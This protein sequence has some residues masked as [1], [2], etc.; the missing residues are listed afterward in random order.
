M[1]KQKIKRLLID[2]AKL[3]KELRIANE[4]SNFS[5]MIYLREKMDNIREEIEMLEEFE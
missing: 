3:G 4:K 5:R 1:N 2:S